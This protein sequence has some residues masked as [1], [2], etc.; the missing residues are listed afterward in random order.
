MVDVRLDLAAAQAFAVDALGHAQA[1]ELH[2]GHVT[3]QVSLTPL[4]IT[5][6]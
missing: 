2:D 5:A 6:E 3:A 4:F 1:V